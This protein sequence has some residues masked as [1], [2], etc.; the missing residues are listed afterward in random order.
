M[1][2][3]HDGQRAAQLGFGEF[4]EEPAERELSR[5]ANGWSR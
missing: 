1:G 5:T 2:T 3:V 4:L